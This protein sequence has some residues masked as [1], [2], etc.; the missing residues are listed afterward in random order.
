MP[1]VL[2]WRLAAADPKGV[3]Y[4]D[5]RARTV[6]VGATEELGDGEHVWFRVLPGAGPSGGPGDRM[7]R[8]RVLVEVRGTDRARERVET[9]TGMYRGLGWVIV[10]DPREFDVSDPPLE[11]EEVLAGW[12][13]VEWVEGVISQFLVRP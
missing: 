9:A 4:R 6:V 7:S 2:V 13:L 1:T 12:P 10:E 8:E 5:A 3:P 11:P